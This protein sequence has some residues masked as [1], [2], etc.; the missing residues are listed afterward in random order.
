M[1]S[2][3]HHNT[4]ARLQDNGTCS[5]NPVQVSIL[6]PCCL[7]TSVG[8]VCRKKM[9]GEV[10]TAS[11]ALSGVGA[12][13]WHRMA[14]SSI[15][16]KIAGDTAWKNN[17]KRWQSK[18]GPGLAVCLVDWNL[19]PAHLG[20]FSGNGSQVLNVNLCQVVLKIQWRSTIGAIC[21]LQFRE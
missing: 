17:D 8:N 1:E 18:A 13:Q 7:Q 19:S 3:H 14:F 6:S 4:Q 11:V 16:L 10:R 15:W 12:R 21:I 2:W 5:V 9:W 20:V